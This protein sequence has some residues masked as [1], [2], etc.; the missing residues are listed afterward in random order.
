MAGI[1]LNS[2]MFMRPRYIAPSAWTGHIPF[3]FWL[4]EQC[5]P[6]VFVELGT[7]AGMSYM[8][9]C[10]AVHDNALKTQCFAVDTWQG[11]EHAGLYGDEV[12]NGLKRDHDV[13]Y[14]GFSQLLR[15]TFDDALSCFDDGAVDVLH[16]DGLHSYEAVR[17]D[18]ETWLPKMSDRGVILFHDTVVRERNFGVWR[19]WSEVSARF[20][21]FEFTHSH[22][23]GVLMVGKHVPEPL[24]GLAS[25]DADASAVSIRRLFEALG[26]FVETTQNREHFERLVVIRDRELAE[27]R[28]DHDASCRETGTFQADI[29]ALRA[30][31]QAR[32]D[33][34]SRTVAMKDEASAAADADARREIA[35]KEQAL[36]EAVADAQREITAKDRALSEAIAGAQREIAAK[37]QAFAEAAAEAKREILAKESLV[38]ECQGRV[39]SIERELVLALA[40]G[41]QLRD[42]L[43]VAVASLASAQEQAEAAA[44]NIRKLSAENEDIRSRAAEESG[45]LRHDLEA[46]N[47][48][49]A[50]VLNSRSW[51]MTKAL[52]WLA[53]KISAGR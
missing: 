1:A 36:T 41:S 46:R 47:T 32:E 4:T 53:R 11:D 2:S 33:D 20:P 28:A 17:H 45:S 35:A 3:A 9:F 24:L 19:L 50:R 43:A 23:L 42:A 49:F 48:E 18:F 16:I 29:S 37:D 34:F 40:D 13:L 12:Y 27:V 30:E 39:E 6:N 52:R 8:G 44:H 51:R 25:A 15:M 7:H 22:G 5:A 10:Q 21:S 26:G 38:I 31:M 14:C